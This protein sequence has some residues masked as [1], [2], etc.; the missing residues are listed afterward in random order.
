V[1]KSWCVMYRGNRWIGKRP[2]RWLPMGRSQ[3]S[4]LTGSRSYVMSSLRFRGI[5]VVEVRA[6]T[7]GAVARVDAVLER[8]EFPHMKK[9]KRAERASVKHIAALES[10]LFRDHMAIVEHM[11]MLQ[12]DDGEP[13][14]A[15]WVTL[16]C[17]GAAWQVV[18]K[19]P[20]GCASFT[21]VGRTLDEALDTAAL[22]LG[23]DEAPWEPDAWLE[24]DAARTRKK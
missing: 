19:D 11:A 18:V 7:W 1:A 5:C 12:Y 13:R 17:I 16:R 21:A 9:V 14:K 4:V 23:S 3:F 24:K 2:A 20:D 15:G 6:K 22:L 8:R 10:N